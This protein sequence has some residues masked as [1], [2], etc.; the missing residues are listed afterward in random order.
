[1]PSEQ[2]ETGRRPAAALVVRDGIDSIGAQQT[3][4]E[5]ELKYLVLGERSNKRPVHDVD[6]YY[7]EVYNYCS[8]NSG[9]HSKSR[10]CYFEDFQFGSPK[11]VEIYEEERNLKEKEEEANKRLTD[12]QQGKD[13]KE[14]EQLEEQ[15]PSKKYQLSDELQREK[16]ELESQSFL[17]WTRVDFKAFLDALRRNGRSDATSTIVEVSKECNKD[18]SD[19]RRYFDT[20]WKRFKEIEEGERIVES[21]GKVEEL[22]VKK[23]DLAAKIAEK[24]DLS[25]ENLHKLSLRYGSMKGKVY[26]DEEDAFLILML[27]KHGYG[28]WKKIIFEIK[29]SWLFRFDSFF[30]SRNTA[31]I[32][33]RVTLIVVL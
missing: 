30:K 19:V 6:G 3:K 7:R 1:M 8:G 14:C 22:L 11:L 2:T 13:E 5:N 23:N 9:V 27:Q 26:S 24:V 10:K 29:N 4:S 31:D 21:I 17:N 15:F 28:E 16:S 25:Q 18:Q 12:L 20:F 32:K 33:K